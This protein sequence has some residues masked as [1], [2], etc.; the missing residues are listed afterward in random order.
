VVEI[1]LAG[2]ASHNGFLMDV[3]SN[4]VPE[5]VWDLLAWVVPHT[6]HLA[7]IIYELLD[8]ALPIVGAAGIRQQ[9]ERARSIWKQTS[10]MTL[11]GGAYGTA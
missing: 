8:P 2:G 7:G 1:H 6:P 11:N 9:L 3:H 10:V 5:A 4:V